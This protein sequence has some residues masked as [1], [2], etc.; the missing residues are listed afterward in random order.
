MCEIEDEVENLKDFMERIK[1]IYMEN[2]NIPKKELTEL[3]KHDLW[4]NSAKCM[5]YSLVDEIM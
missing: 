3:L 2:T 1:S 5:K 4:L